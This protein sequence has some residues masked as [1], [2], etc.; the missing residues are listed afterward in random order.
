M[1]RA[2]PVQQ[3]S[4]II[5]KG[6]RAS[7]KTKF[8]HRPKKAGPSVKKAKGRGILQFCGGFRI[9]AL[10]SL[11]NSIHQRLV[12]QIEENIGILTKKGGCQ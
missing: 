1:N 7:G 9:P 5:I 10:F 11:W 4:F 6:T 3:A 2:K 8:R 12:S